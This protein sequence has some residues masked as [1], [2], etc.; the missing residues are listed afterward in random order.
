MLSDAKIAKNYMTR[1]ELEELTSLVNLCLD[2][3]TLMVKRK[4]P[5]YMEEWVEQVNAQLKI[6]GYT[7]LTGKGSMSREEAEKIVTKVYEE[8]RPKQD[9]M[10]LSDFDSLVSKTLGK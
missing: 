4:R 5:I 7:I 2:S 8:Y 6:H 9:Q 1:D 10:F 3:A